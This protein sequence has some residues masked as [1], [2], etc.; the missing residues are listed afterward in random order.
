MKKLNEA[1]DKIRN[2][3]IICIM[4]QKT[5]LC[6]ENGAINVTKKVLFYLI[7]I[8]GKLYVEISRVG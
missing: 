6:I 2:Q 8:Y 5:L 1:I 4:G 3:W 7:G